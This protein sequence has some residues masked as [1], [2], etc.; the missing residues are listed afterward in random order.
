[1]LVE[2]MPNA[3]LIDAN[4]ILEWRLTPA[5]LDDLLAGFLDETYSEGAGEAVERTARRAA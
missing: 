4:S 2:E 1:M 5:R 3:R